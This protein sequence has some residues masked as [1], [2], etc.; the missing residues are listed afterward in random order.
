MYP[1]QIIQILL[2]PTLDLVD[3][4]DSSRFTVIT[5]SCDLP[6]KEKYT[7]TRIPSTHTALKANPPKKSYKTVTP[8]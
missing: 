8:K 6:K 2:S 3:L 5:V 1:P 4:F 7:Y